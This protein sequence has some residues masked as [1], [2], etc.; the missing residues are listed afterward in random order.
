LSRFHEAA[1]EAAT[2]IGDKVVKW[3]LSSCRF[4]FLAM[5]VCSSQATQVRS[6]KRW[7]AYFD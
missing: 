6:K 2:G 5:F 4:Q 7:L 1:T 3:S